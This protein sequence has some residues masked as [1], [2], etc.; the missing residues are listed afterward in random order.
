MAQH[1]YTIANQTFP[2]TRTDLNNALAAIVSANSGATA[3]TTTYGYQLWY[4]T[5]TD[6]LKMRNANDDAWIDLFDVDQVADTAAPSTGG[7]G[8]AS[9]SLFEFTATSGQTTFSG[10]D[11]N[12]ATLS[13][14]AGKIIVVMNGITLDPS[15]YTATNGTSV[16]LAAGASSGDL[17]NI[18]AFD[19]F[20]VADT[21]SA[22]SGGT[23]NGG[24][25]IGGDL[26]VDTNTLYVDS[27]NNRVG[28]GTSSPSNILHVSG[29]SGTPVLLE[30]TNGA[31]CTLAFKG[32]ATTNNPYLGATSDDLYFNTGNTERMRIDSNGNVLVGKTSASGSTQGAEMR[33]DGRILAVSTSDF[34][35]YFNR[36]STDGEIVR[37]VKDTTTVG[38][39]GAF[40]SG[41][42]ALFFGSLDTAL[43][44]NSGNDS[45]HPWN[46]ST[47]S[48]RDNA[49]DLGNSG[50][51]FDDIYATN[52]TIQ[53]SDAN[54]KQ[55]IASLTD[56]EI[57]AAKA[58]SALFKTFKWNDA[59]SEKGDAARTH[60]GV[61]A[62]DV[63]AAMTAAG[64]D[65]GDYAFFISSTWYVDADGN[66]VEADA[67]GAIEKNRKGI[68]YPELLAFVGAATEQRLANIET[69]LA[70]LENA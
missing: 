22:A 57:T 65:A 29:T 50:N 18:Y 8:T 16:V 37:F 12:A 70:A 41:T 66:E 56:A 35:G 44:A 45:I 60:A 4:D 40:T 7:G 55:Q 42:S 31:A 52:G 39:I 68:R 27:T 32:N 53:T 62:Q 19:S 64:L 23:F 10:A 21:V 69:R 54:E 6:I 67:E 38:S 47:N 2:A 48:N 11:D 33:G 49:I 26:T 58:I 1:D 3:P 17:V 14:S 5:T 13:Y 36:K 24:I 28:I 63:Q 30:R 34:A 25:T 9:F 46:A 15:D 20:S 59:V 61:I 51:R 43:L